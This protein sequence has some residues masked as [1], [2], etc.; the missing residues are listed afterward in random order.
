MRYYKANVNGETVCMLQNIANN[1]VSKSSIAKNLTTTT[2]GMV[3]DATQGK[4]LNDKISTLNYSLE[5]RLSKSLVSTETINID[6]LS[7]SSGG[8]STMT[9]D[10]IS[11]SGY[12][13]V[14]ANFF[15]RG[16]YA[17]N[18]IASFTIGGSSTKIYNF[19]FYNPSDYDISAYGYVDL[20]YVA[21]SL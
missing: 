10:E 5:N 8:Y 18:I 1:S 4:A 7:L 15:L 9:S 13:L 6:N 12:T 17:E 16:S 20:I 21:N 14:G 2:E 11:K 19:A 3:L